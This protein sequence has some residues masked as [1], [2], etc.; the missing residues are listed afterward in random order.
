MRASPR[1]AIIGAG[2]AGLT[3]A[4]ELAAQGI[5]PVIFDKGRGLGGRLSTRR[6]EGGFQ[7]DH[8]AR[9]LT[10]RGE[11]FASLLLAAETA[12]AV[13]RW[14]VE[15]GEAVFVGIPGMTGLAKFMADGLNI[16]KAVRITHVREAEGGWRL[17]WKEG[18]EVFDRVVITAPSPQTIALLA[19]D[20]PIR[21]SIESVGMDPCLA[22]M[23]GMSPDERVPPTIQLQPS[24]DLSWVVLD[25][26]K[27][28]RPDVPCLVAHASPDWSRRHLELEMTEIAQRMLPLVSQALGTR[29]TEDLPYLS[30]HRWRYA[31]VSKPLGQPFLVDKTQTLFAGGDWC[32]G[33][34][35]EDAWTSGKAVASTVLKTI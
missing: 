15:E 26:T 22:L 16:R 23:V 28:G 13:A 24:D 3:C 29:L 12:G 31:L 27:P 11:D 9:Y 6:A 5:D 1:I 18:A 10:A 32:L 8:G 2:L 14:H 34:R 19:E 17:E 30:A 21:R 7:F 25:S 4:R 20:H 35:A 33:A